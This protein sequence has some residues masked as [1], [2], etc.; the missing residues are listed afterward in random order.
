MLTA[1]DRALLQKID[2]QTASTNTIVTP[3]AAVWTKTLATVEKSGNLTR[4]VWQKLQVDRYLQYA[5]YALNLHNAF[6]LSKNIAESAS[7]ML[8]TVLQVVGWAPTDADNNPISLG[9]I[10]SQAIGSVFNSVVGAT[11]AEALKATLQSYSRTYQAATNVLYTVGSIVDSS[12]AISEITGEHVGKIGNA[13]KSA[14]AV[15]EN[16]YGWMPEKMDAAHRVT[17]RWEKMFTKLETT[18]NV[19]GDVSSIASEVQSIQQTTQELTT[20]REELRAAM[21]DIGLGD[22]PPSEPITQAEDFKKVDSEAPENL[23]S[24][25]VGAREG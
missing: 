11:N 21:K 17:G 7:F 16:A 8:D 22:T 24:A 2:R 23:E 9:T 6:Y 3:A 15:Q 1:A 19:V 14:G 4:R 5:N 12:R 13:L 20:E 10:A 18:E 25:T